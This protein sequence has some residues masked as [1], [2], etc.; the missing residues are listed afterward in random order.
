MF[1][2]A[3]DIHEERAVERAFSEWADGDSIAAHIAYG[4][5]IFCSDDVGKSNPT[6]SVL[7]PNHRAWLTQI[8]GVQFMAFEDLAG[9]LS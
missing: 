7:D 3:T 2:P 6:N 1:E 5:D 4:L 9:S 8:Y